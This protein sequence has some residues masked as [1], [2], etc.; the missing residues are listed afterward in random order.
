MTTSYKKYHFVVSYYC[1]INEYFTDGVS[2]LC[3]KTA[4]VAQTSFFII[5]KVS[6]KCQFI[7]K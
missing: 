7:I 1:G 5:S 2:I 4:N 3:K 6:S